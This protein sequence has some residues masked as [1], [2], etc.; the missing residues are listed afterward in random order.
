MFQLSGFY[1]IGA[2]IVALENPYKSHL[3]TRRVRQSETPKQTQ[4]T[5]KELKIEPLHP[6]KPSQEPLRTPKGTKKEPLAA[7]L[8]GTL[9]ETS[10]ETPKGT[11]KETLKA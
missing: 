1:C 11:L 2:L 9:E 10:Q 8:K 3:R 6:Q 7:T 5:P 4:E